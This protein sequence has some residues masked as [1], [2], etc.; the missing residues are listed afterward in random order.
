ME[1]CKSIPLFKDGAHDI[2]GN[3]RPISVL[4]VFS[5]LLEKHVAGFFM[6][7]LTRN[8]LLYDLQSAFREGHST[9]SA[10]IK[11]TDQILFDLDRDEVTD[12]D[13][14]DHQFL[15]T[16]LRLYRLNLRCPGPNLMLRT[17]TSL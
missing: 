11:L 16:K 5:K 2:R 3:C 10:L 12:I 8:D 7:Y 1:S 14:V 9:E 17:D 6:D 15:L 4:P 13:L